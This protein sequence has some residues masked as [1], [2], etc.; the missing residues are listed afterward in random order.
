MDLT[1]IVA[2]VEGSGLGEWMRSSLKAMPVVEAIHVMAIALVFGTILIVDLRLLGLFDTQRSITRVSDELLRWTWWAFGV[3]AVT[4]ALMFSANATT[5]F[6][7]TPFRLKMLALIAA[8]ANMAIFQLVTFK[9]VAEWD[10]N[11]P[12]PAAA[13]MAAALSITLWTSVIF[14]GRWVGFTKGYDFEIPDELDFDFSLL[15][16]GLHLMHEAIIPHAFKLGVT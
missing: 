7:N 15:E 9:N 13:R 1:S 5:Y 6:V 12:A 3:A 8:G 2:S 11:A 16:S 14:L 4:G 10:R